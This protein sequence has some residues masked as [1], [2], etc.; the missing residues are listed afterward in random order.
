MRFD[1][2]TLAR[3]WLAVAHASSSDKV[4]PTLYRTVIVEEF[5]SG[6]RLWATD[7]VLLLTAWVPDLD[8]WDGAEPEIDQAP[9]RVV[10]CADLDGRAR[11]LFGY[12]LALQGRLPVDVREEPGEIELGMRFDAKL[13]AGAGGDDAT[14]DGMDPTF[15]VLDVPDTER[16]YLQV[17]EAQ[18]PDW[19]PIVL[20]H[21][22]RKADRLQV[23]AEVLERVAKVRKHAAGPLEWRFG[24]RERAAR[25]VYP[26]SDPLI[27]GVFMPRKLEVPGHHDTEPCRACEAGLCLR[28][29]SGVVTIGP[30]SDDVDLELLVQA[31]ET[32]LT[33]QNGSTG[34]LKRTLHVGSAK[35]QRIAGMLQD[36]GVIAAEAEPGQAPEVLF[37]AEELEALLTIVRDV[38]A[39]GDELDAAMTAD[40]TEDLSDGLTVDLSTAE[41]GEPPMPD[42]G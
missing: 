36:L 10:I 11:S 40:L 37:P 7:R 24:G 33:T 23:T 35:A 21:E 5:P 26:E 22:N 30:D 38:A 28:H 18:A 34:H 16:V 2:P 13:P 25:I 12:V 39:A 32:V 14:L 17:V 8:S 6:V 19:R 29:G 4:L 41:D 15:T 27:E 1:G 3:A 9:D 20:G 31:V 42:D